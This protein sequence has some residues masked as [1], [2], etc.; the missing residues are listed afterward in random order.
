MEPLRLD[1][2]RQRDARH[3]GAVRAHARGHGLE[4]LLGGRQLLPDLGESH[5]R[6]PRGP[7]GGD[8][9]W[10][11][12]G[13]RLRGAGHGVPRG[14]VCEQPVLC[15]GNRRDRHLGPRRPLRR[16]DGP[17]LPRLVGHER[18]HLAGG[19]G[20]HDALSALGLRPRIAERHGEARVAERALLRQRPGP[21][22]ERAAHGGCQGPGRRVAC[23]VDGV[24]GGVVAGAWLARLQVGATL[25]RHAG[26]G[27]LDAHSSPEGVQVG[28]GGYSPGFGAQHLRRR[29]G[30]PR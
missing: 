3:A 17:R 6:E 18:P 22:R 27:H 4:H 5:G 30:A 10:A 2:H 7:R 14:N 21:H 1:V 19:A 29:R 12:R 26:L 24:S 13:Q 28:S 11:G 23:A 8:A 25:L 20:Q 9:L 16:R 15:H